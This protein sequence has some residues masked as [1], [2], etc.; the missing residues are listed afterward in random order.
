MVAQRPGG[1]GP[2]EGLKVHLGEF[3]HQ[4]VLHS[5]ASPA[6]SDQKLARVLQHVLGE[7]APCDDLVAGKHATSGAAAPTNMHGT[8][9]TATL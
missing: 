9:A 6:T 1:S 3:E 8:I 5:Q 2:P 7:E 4:H